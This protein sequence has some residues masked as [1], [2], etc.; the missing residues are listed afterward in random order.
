MFD[1]NKA[2]IKEEN[3]A[4]KQEKSDANNIKEESELS[5]MMPKN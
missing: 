4:P 3:T 5:L 1:K 2:K